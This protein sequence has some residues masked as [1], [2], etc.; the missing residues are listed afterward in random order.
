MERKAGLLKGKQVFQ[1]WKDEEFNRCQEIL[2]NRETIYSFCPQEQGQAGDLWTVILWP[3][4]RAAKGMRL[5]KQDQSAG[6]VLGT[7]VKAE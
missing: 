7:E 2:K 5:R 3:F 6:S 1:R 4:Q